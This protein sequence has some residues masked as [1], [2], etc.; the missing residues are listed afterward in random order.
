MVDTGWAVALAG[1]DDYAGFALVLF[2]KDYD[3]S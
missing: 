2:L 3:D 1:I